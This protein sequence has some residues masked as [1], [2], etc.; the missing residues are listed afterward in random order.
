MRC[1]SLNYYKYLPLGEGGKKSGSN[2]P[3]FLTDEGISPA[4]P[5]NKTTVIL[6]E[7][8]ESKD[9][10]KRSTNPTYKKPVT[11]TRHSAWRDDRF[12]IFRGLRF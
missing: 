9:P 4:K 7:R 12:S 8:S 6:S 11:P 10:V 1:R 3:D 2:E 5:E